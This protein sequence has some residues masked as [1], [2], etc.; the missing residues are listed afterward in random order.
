M[1]DKTKSKPFRELMEFYLKSETSAHIA[2]QLGDIIE[3]MDE[4]SRRATDWTISAYN[5]TA[6]DRDFWKKDCV[7]VFHEISDTAVTHFR[8][9]NKTAESDALFEI[10]HAVILALAYMTHEDKG[11]RKSSG[12][13][14]GFWS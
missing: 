7:T 2:N 14:K 6:R 12:L 4:K 8:R 1:K 9:Q 10:V 5:T 3:A 11:F 13:K